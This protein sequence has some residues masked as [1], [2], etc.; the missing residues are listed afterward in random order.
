MSLQDL[1]SSV[2][3]KFTAQ[4]NTGRGYLAVKISSTSVLSTTWSVAAGDVKLGAVAYAALTDGSFENLLQTSD[5]A[6]SESLSNSSVEISQVVFAV[7]FHWISEGK[8]SSVKLKDLRAI[9]KELDLV[10]LGYVSLTEALESYY[11]EV[12]G[13]PL[14]AILVGIEGQNSTLTIYRAGKHLGT[15]FLGLTDYHE[16]VLPEGIERAL[17]KLNV[18]DILP[19]RIILYDGKSDLTAAVAKVTAYPWTA[20]LPFLHFPKVETASAEFVVKAVAVAGA[21]QQ[22]GRFVAFDRDGESTVVDVPVVSDTPPVAASAFES[23]EVPSLKQVLKE[24]E[25]ELLEVSPEEAGFMSGSDLNNVIVSVASPTPLATTSSFTEFAPPTPSPKIA[26]EYTASNHKGGLNL[27]TSLSGLTKK[28]PSFS[29]KKKALDSGARTTPEIG[30]IS[31]G[32]KFPLIAFPIIFVVL[33]IGA[34]GALAYFVPKAEIFVTVATESFSHDLD[35]TVVTDRDSTS[36]GQILLGSYVTTSEVGSRRAVA[37]GNKLVGDRAKGTVTIYNSASARTFP[38]G[39]VLTGNGLKFTTDT[40]VSVASS[41][42]IADQITVKVGVTAADIGEKYN[43]PPGVTFSVGSLPTS[44]Y[45]GK[46]EAALAGGNSHQATVV[47][48]GDQDRLL[49]TLSGELTEQ[50]QKALEAKLGASDTLLPKAITSATIK[51]KFTHDIDAEADTFGLDLTL[52]FKGV[53]FAKDDLVELF[54]QNFQSAIAEGFE[55]SSDSVQFEVKEAKTDKAGNI[56]LKVHLD[57]QI[58]PKIAV[59]QIVTDSAGKS[60]GQAT[61]SIAKLPGVTGVRVEINPKIASPLATFALP[62]NKKHISVDIV[63]E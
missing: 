32:R 37:T 31:K 28:I 40:E 29:F 10:P 55:L 41:S 51:K 45:Q 30:G 18:G 2:A 44:S 20:K 49:T 25:D 23:V 5:K 16:D 43:L 56:V 54:K 62:W 61:S 52:D 57:G 19:S 58:V 24:Q 27:M 4:K 48:K 34:T 47:T 26:G 14:T 3:G 17:K 22:G 9:C 15:H 39:T 46:N 50:A 12:E 42:G 21:M 59:E 33:L 11:K 36:S 38:A 53:T 35:V 13:A 7:P 60:L 1:V 6:V 8:I 63:R